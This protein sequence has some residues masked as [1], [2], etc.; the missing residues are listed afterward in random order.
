M[1]DTINDGVDRGSW[2][3]DDQAGTARIAWTSLPEPLDETSDVARAARAAARVV[4]RR[5]R[6][7]KSSDDPAEPSVI[8]ISTSWQRL[9]KSLGW[10]SAPAMDDGSHPLR[11][12]IFLCPP[13]LG[14]AYKRGLPSTDLGSLYEWIAGQDPLGFLPALVLNPD[15]AVPELRLHEAGL[16]QPEIVSKY[17]L[18]FAHLDLETLDR[19]LARFYEDVVC[20]PGGGRKCV[21]LWNDPE[22]FQ[23]VHRPEK[24]IQDELVRYLRASLPH[25]RATEEE[26]TPLGRLDV[27]LTGALAE[28]DTIVV[29]H[30]VI[31]L[32]VL[33]GGNKK[34]PFTDTQGL[35]AHVEKG[36]RQAASYR[37]PPGESR[38]AMLG[39][40]DMRPHAGHR[41]ESCL[42]HIRQFAHDER[43]EIRRWPLFP[44]V[45]ALRVH[46]V[47]GPPS[48]P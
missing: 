7:A 35:K 25:L 24:A 17:P 19:V 15:A 37:K 41:G 33:N 13:N 44:N 38:I 42:D 14:A 46:L 23:A 6:N 10:T 3:G 21:P 8:L 4:M 26:D 31:E 40:Y 5:A 1:P 2:T 28:D 36:V 29:S 12:S 18:H 22:A 16:G 43:V 27:R 48:S 34:G 9:G 45:E 32:K 39:C 20:A 11:G 30:A 47:P